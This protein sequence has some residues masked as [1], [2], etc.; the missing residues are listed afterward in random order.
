MPK[1]R[2]ILVLA[3]QSARSVS[4]VS[5]F[6]SRLHNIKERGVIRLDRLIAATSPSR[7]TR[8]DL[9]DND[10]A[11]E[12]NTIP[13]ALF[14]RTKLRILV[15]TRCG[16]NGKVSPTFRNLRCLREPSN[17]F[18]ENAGMMY[19]A[20]ESRNGLAKNTK[21]GACTCGSSIC[22]AAGAKGPLPHRTAMPG[23]YC[24]EEL[25]MCH[26][27]VIPAPCSLSSAVEKKKA[28]SDAAVNVC[29]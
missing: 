12:P 17:P 28:C 22:M 10:W 29:L 5:C 20:C 14:L 9:D 27:Q 1:H 16:L 26:D 4:C 3:A 15:L 18:A 6:H 2:E 8:L 19:P 13:D 25:S 23:M 11:D 24:A 21:F 7:L